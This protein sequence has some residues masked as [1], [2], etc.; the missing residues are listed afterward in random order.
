VTGTLESQRA[1]DCKR[2]V[3]SS[4]GAIIEEDD[5]SDFY[6]DG[7]ECTFDYCDGGAVNVAMAEIVCPNKGEGYCSAGECVSCIVGQF[8]GLQCKP[9]QTCAYGLCVPTACQNG[10]MDGT[11]SDIDC[12]GDCVPCFEGDACNTGADCTSGVCGPEMT[13]KAPL[14]DDGFKNNGE[15]DVDCGAHCPGKPCADGKGCKAGEDCSSGVCWAGQCQVPSCTDGVKNGAE[16]DIDCGS[17][18]LD[19]C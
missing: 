16:Q 6:D 9:G 5:P 14:C 19:G 2:R 11:E 15:T 4:N 10:A 18:C 7:L 3:C 17:G 13:C 8:A 1:G 12:G